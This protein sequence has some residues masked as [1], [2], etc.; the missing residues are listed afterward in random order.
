MGNFDGDDYPDIL[1]GNRL[2][3]STSDHG[4]GTHATAS[5]PRCHEGDLNTSQRN[6]I[7]L[8]IVRDSCFA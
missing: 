4:A 5:P 7:L 6:E 1:I 2:F 3:T 8:I